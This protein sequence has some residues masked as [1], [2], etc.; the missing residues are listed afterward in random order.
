MSEAKTDTTSAPVVHR[1]CIWCDYVT[2][3]SEHWCPRCKDEDDGPYTYRALR[4]MSDERPRMML[5]SEAK[6]ML[7]KLAAYYGEPVF[8][9]SRYC[10]A[11]YLW[12]RAI[13]KANDPEDFVPRHEND[14]I[15]HKAGHGYARSIGRMLTDITKSNLLARLLYG[16]EKLRKRQCPEHKGHWSGM[17]FYESRCKHGCGLTGWLPEDDDP[18]HASTR[19]NDALLLR[20]PI[21]TEGQA[22]EV[23]AILPEE[24]AVTLASLHAVGLHGMPG[25]CRYGEAFK[26]IWTIL[27]RNAERD[28]CWKAV[29]HVGGH[30]LREET[31]E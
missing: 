26:P 21:M 9:I 12:A 7:D 4:E 6:E 18:A 1:Y 25:M 14:K 3:D 5:A 10:R 8:P 24:E 13:E 22:R 20:M 28:W 19:R 11:F 30:R 16:G 31:K 23:L 27:Y 2:A 15:E 17:E 29:D